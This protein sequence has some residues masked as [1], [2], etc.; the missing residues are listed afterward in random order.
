M[1]AL[2]KLT[3]EELIVTCKRFQSENGKLQD[4]LD[5]LSDC[6]TELENGLADQINLLD[7]LDTIK[8]VDNFKWRLR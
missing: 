7:S 4:E 3:K 5:R 1:K 6:Y 8:D 2:Y